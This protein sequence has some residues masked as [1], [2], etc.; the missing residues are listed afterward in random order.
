M[1]KNKALN[2]SEPN[3]Q[4]NDINAVKR[5]LKARWVSTSG[6]EISNFEEK[7]ASFIGTK[8]ALA[9]NSGT[10]SLHLALL[11]AGIEEGDEVLVQS[12][13]FIATANPILYLKATPIFFDVDKKF[14]INIKH[15]KNFI[16]TRTFYRNNKTINK[17]TKKQIKALLVSHLWGNACD[18]KGIKS[19]LNKKNI[20][21][22]EDSAESLGSIVIKRKKKIMCGSQ[23]DISC[24]S[25]NGNK[26]IT[27]GSGGAFL[28]NNKKFFNRA[29]YL[30]TQAKDDD[31]AYVHNDVG[32]NYRLNN[33]SAALGLSQL[34]RIK[35]IVKKKFYIH[36]VYLNQFQGYKNASILTCKNNKSTNWLNILVFKKKLSNSKFLNLKLHLKKSNI[37]IR[38]VW[39]PCHSQKK[40]IKFEK[41]KIFTSNELYN[42]CICLPSDIKL[43]ERD[44]KK[45]S[46]KIKI[47][48]NESK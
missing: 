15:V 40:F 20:L 31:F 19:Y 43:N 44:I 23:G 2:L 22:I 39:K 47:Y 33:I 9:T 7:I 12:L 45:I 41:Y 17:K 35:R 34:K 11:I 10:S 13:T 21:L 46:D 28:T 27:T 29:K 4:S 30:S 36:K 5:V 37:Q 8:Y 16:E 6:P 1:F 14:N 3:I 18:L 32:Y 24:L 25:F 42:K 26:I 38:R 48:Y